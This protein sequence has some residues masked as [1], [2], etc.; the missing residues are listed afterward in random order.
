MPLCFSRKRWQVLPPS[1][2]AST[3]R[4]M[5]ANCAASG[6]A[7]L[8]APPSIE[9]YGEKSDYANEFHRALLEIFHG[10]TIADKPRRWFQTQDISK[11]MLRTRSTP[12]DCASPAARRAL[13]A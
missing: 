13:P 1:G 11:V 5:L 10:E 9:Q 2:K 4:A 8:C 7:L 12:A 3:D 6:R